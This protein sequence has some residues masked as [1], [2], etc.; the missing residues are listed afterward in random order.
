MFVKECFKYIKL[1]FNK[2]EYRFDFANKHY[3]P[4]LVQKIIAK[5]SQRFNNQD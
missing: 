5:I 3:E 4:V 2:A 1:K